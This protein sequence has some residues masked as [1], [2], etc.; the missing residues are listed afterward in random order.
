MHYRP[1]PGCGFLVAT[2]AEACPLCSR[3]VVLDHDAPATAAA[4]VAVPPAGPG[5]LLPPGPEEGRPASGG[6]VPEPSS[7]AVPADRVAPP[8]TP[9]AWVAPMGPIEEPRSGPG[10]AAVPLGIAVLSVLAMVV[11]ALFGQSERSAGATGVTLAD[12]AEVAAALP[13]TLPPGWLPYTDPGVPFLVRFPAQPGARQE[14]GP[15]GV[16]LYVVEAVAGDVVLAVQWY[17]LPAAPS[18]D[19]LEAVLAAGAA[20]AAPPGSV[21]GP[22]TPGALAGRRSVSTTFTTPDGREGRA[23]AVV[24]DALLLRLVGSG[25]PGAAAEPLARMAETFAVA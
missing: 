7:A 4:A 1:C 2:D 24:R 10:D 21:V 22:P 25:P 14:P 16:P 8:V 5:H 9:A 3:G 20:G 11:L 17:D 18:Q 13:T 19:Q 12:P 15:D 6:P 23:M